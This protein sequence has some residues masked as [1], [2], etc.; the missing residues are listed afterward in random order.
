MSLCLTGST[1]ETTVQTLF[2]VLAENASGHPFRKQA[3]LQTWLCWPGSDGRSCCPL[4]VCRFT[5]HLTKAP[6]S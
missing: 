2:A 5:H 6:K 3:G 4:Y 1:P